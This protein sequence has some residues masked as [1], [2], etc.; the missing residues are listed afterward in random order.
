[1][2]PGEPGEARRGAGEVLVPGL[3][4]RRVGPVRVALR[5]PAERG[6]DLLPSLP[7]GFAVPWPAQ[8]G[9]DVH[10][11]AERG[12]E[13]VSALEDAPPGRGIQH[14][15]RRP[16]F[17]LLAQPRG[18]AGHLL[19]ATV[20]EPG[21]GLVA[22]GDPGEVAVR[23]AVPGEDHLGDH[24]HRVPPV[25]AGPAAGCASCASSLTGRG[26]RWSGCGGSQPR[27]SALPRSAFL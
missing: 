14:I 7:V 15:E 6:L 13:D 11:Q 19:A 2:P 10:R 20:R 26:N 17:L 16:G 9:L 27:P 21:A 8:A 25:T 24:G 3:R 12:G 5:W 1:M 18:P 23:L 22:A 4:S